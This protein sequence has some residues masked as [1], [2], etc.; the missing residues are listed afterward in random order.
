M[1]LLFIALFSTLIYPS[2]FLTDQAKKMNH[3]KH[4]AGKAWEVKVSQTK[5]FTIEPYI[6]N[7]IPNI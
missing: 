7:N 5:T 1:K 6:F 2:P 4:D 3:Q